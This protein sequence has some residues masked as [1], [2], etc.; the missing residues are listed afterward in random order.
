MSDRAKHFNNNEIKFVGQILDNVHGFIPYTAA[1]Q[2]IM[3]LQLFKRLQSIKQLSVVNWVFPGSEHTRYIHSLGV[4]HIA[5]KMAVALGLENYER[6]ILRLAGLLHDIGHYPQSHVCETPYKNAKDEEDNKAAV[7]LDSN[8]DAFCRKHNLGIRGKISKFAIEQ[9]TS[10]MSTR[11]GLHHEAVGADIVLHNKDIIEILRA[12]CGNPS[13]HRI[14]ADII[15]GNIESPKR[16]DPLWVQ[17]LHSEM[18]ADGIDYMMRDSAFAGTS[19]GSCEI[20]QLIRC[21]KIGWY[22]GYQI[23]C[24]RPKGVAAADQYLLNKFF[25]YAQVV[26][27]RHIVISEWMAEIIT[28]WMRQNARVFPNAS[29]L[30]HWATKDHPKLLNFTDNLFW[31]ALEQLATEDEAHQVPEYIKIFCKCLLRHDEPTFLRQDEV[32]FITNN[33]GEAIKMLASSPIVNDDKLLTQQIATLNVQPITKQL[34]LEK[35]Q[36]AL[37]EEKARKK[38]QLADTTRMD[39]EPDEDTI[40]PELARMMECITVLEEDGNTIRV[41]CDHPRSLMRSM[42]DQTLVILRT[43]D[44]PKDRDLERTQ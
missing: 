5:D 15:T 41:L 21:L 14:I 37:I 22:K 26:C 12:E 32:R 6:R 39:D 44:F 29:T 30:N 20:D 7:P 42:Y 1:E 3:Q 18:D 4:M 43:Y 17:I 28:L 13:A 10:L 2:Q 9:K 8:Q 38:A 36:Q 11:T 40:S 34:P 16:T 19:F 25:H 24:I 23:L 27:N 35:F 33:A 31:S